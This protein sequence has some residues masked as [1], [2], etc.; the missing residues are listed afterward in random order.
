[1]EWLWFIVLLGSLFGLSLILLKIKVRP[2]NYIFI[3]IVLAA[4]ILYVINLT[5]L[6]GSYAIPLNLVTIFTVGILGIPGF[7]LLLSLKLLFI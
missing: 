6:L 1:M 4:V 3:N 2:I 7:A 5:G